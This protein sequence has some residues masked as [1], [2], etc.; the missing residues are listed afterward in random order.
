MSMGHNEKTW[1]KYLCDVGLY[2][3][4]NPTDANMRRTTTRG[5]NLEHKSCFE[6]YLK[7]YRPKDMS[8]IYDKFTSN[9]L[10]THIMKATI[11]KEWWKY[12]EY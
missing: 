12:N 7:C 4:N 2:E 6:P 3:H 11:T 9:R 1:G 10:N 8:I 5:R